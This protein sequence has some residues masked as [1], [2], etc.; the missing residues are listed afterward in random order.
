MS[1][2]PLPRGWHRRVAS[3]AIR[4]LLLAPFVLGLPPAEAQIVREASPRIYIGGEPVELDDRCVVNIGNRTAQVGADGDFAIPNVPFEAGVRSRVRAVCNRNGRLLYGSSRLLDLEDDRQPVHIF[5]D[6]Y[7]PLVRR[8]QLFPAGGD[9]TITDPEATL[10]IIALGEHPDGRQIFVSSPTAG[11]VWTS[12]D[13]TV[14]TVDVDGIVTPLR[15]GEVII[16][17]QI[18]G[19]SSSL[20]I[21]VD[22]PNDRDGDGL[23]DEYEVANGLDP[24]DPG[25]ALLDTDLDGLDNVQEFAAGT[26]PDL[27]DSDGDSLLDGDEVD[28]DLD[29]RR[30]DSDGDRLLDGEELRIGTDPNAADSDGDGIEDGAEVDFGLD[31]LSPDETTTVV[32]RAVTTEGAAVAGAVVLVDERFQ[33]ITN[34]AGAFEIPG[35][36]VEAPRIQVKAR[37]IERGAVLDGKIRVAPVPAGVTDVGELRL[38]AVRGAVGGTIV[39][40]RGAPVPGARVFVTVGDD[41]RAIN[42]NAAGQYLLQR[43]DEGPVTVVATDPTTGL[44]GRSV[45]ELIPDASVTVDVALTASGTIRGTVYGRGRAAVGEGIPVVLRGPV[46]LETTTDA[47]SRFQFDFIPLGVYT[48]EAFD[49]DGDR[50][51]TTAAINGTNQTVQAD[52]TFLGRGRVTGVVE[53]GGGALVAG[54]QVELVGDGPFGGRA[55]A[56][57]DAQGTF[58]IDDVFIGPF[59]ITAR[60]PL[61][62]LAATAS[63]QVRFEGDTARVTLTLR[64]AGNIV[65]TVLQSDE[66]TPLPG[67]RVTID[68]GGRQLEADAAGQVR[69]EGLP[70]GRYTVTAVDPETPDRGRI[71]VDLL[72]PDVDVRATVTLRGLGAVEVTVR[73]AGGAI[74]PNT[75]VTLTGRTPFPQTQVGVTDGDGIARFD[76]ILAGG[77]SLAAVEPLSGLT[78]AVDSNVLAD[79]V[80]PLELRLESAGV[81]TGTAVAA[82]G[83]T[84]VRGILMVLEPGG[85]RA[86]TDAA[87]R[88]RFDLVPVANGPFRIDAIDGTGTRR[89]RAE[90][91]ELR[92]HGEVLDRVIQLGGTGLV[93]GL[94]T[95]PEGVPVAGA[96]ITIDSAVDGAPRRF[97]TT[98]PAGVYLLDRIPEGRFTVSASL[99]AGR[100]AGQAAGEIQLDGEIIE[101]DVATARDV[102]PQPGGGGGGGAVPPSLQNPR[103]ARLFDANNLEHAIHQDGSIRNGTQSVF[104]GDGG[105]GSGGFLLEL[106]GEGDDFAPFVGRG[107]QLDLGGRQLSLPGDGPGGLEVTRRV[108]V[109]RD[110]YFVRYL[111]VLRNPTGAPITVDLRIRTHFGFTTEAR[112]G[113]TFTDPPQLVDSSSGDGFVLAGPELGPAADRWAVIDDTVDADPFVQRNAPAVAHVFDGAGGLR[114]ASGASFDLNGQAFARLESVWQA[115]TVPPGGRA[116]IMHFGVQQLDRFAALTAAERLAEAPPEAFEGIDALDLNG[117]LNFPRLAGAVD[118]LP[119]RDGAVSGVVFEGDGETTVPRARLVW[120]SGHPLFG[121]R[122][123]ITA[124]DDG[125]YAIAPRLGGNGNNIAIPRFDFELTAT[126]PNTGIR[127][128]ITPGVFPAEGDAAR[129]V[130]FGNAGLIGGVVRRADGNVVSTGQVF[131]RGGDFRADPR[132]DIAVDGRFAITGVPPGDYTVEARV[133]VADGSPLG[134]SARANLRAGET[135]DVAIV[136]DP[137]GGLVG[138]VR[139]GGGNPAIEVPVEVLGEGLERAGRSDTG[140]RYAFLDVPTGVVTARA[141]EPATGLWSERLVAVLDGEVAERDLDLVPLGTARVTVIDSDGA[142]AVDAPIHIRRAPLG[143]FFRAAGRTGP[144]GVL[145]LPIVPQ[146]DFT[147]RAFS[148]VNDEIA[149]EADGRIERHGQVVLV[150]LVVPVDQPPQVL[151]REPDTGDEALEGTVTQI[152]AEAIDDLGVRR[153]EFFADGIAIG[154]DTSPPYTADY[155]MPQGDGGA[156]TL[157]A[158]AVDGGQNRTIS[159]PVSLLRRDDDQI[160]TIRFLAPFE[161]AAFIEGTPVDIRLAAA[162]DVGVARVELFAGE[163]PIAVIEEPPFDAQFAA[164]LGLADA[165]PAPLVV[166]AAVTDRAGNRAEAELII[167]VVA[168]QPPTIEVIEAPDGPVVEG[169]AV[170]LTARATDDVGATVDLVID[171]RVAQTRPRAPYRFDLTAPPA[172]AEPTPV[173]LRARDARGQTAEAVVELEVIADTPPDVAIESPA[174]GARITEGSIVSVEASAVDEVGVAEV[175]FFAG[176]TLIATRQAPPYTAQTR[177]PGGAGGEAVTIRVEAVDT[178]GQTAAV[179]RDVIREDD[180]TPPTGAITSPPAGATLTVG[181]SDVML[182]FARDAGAAG[183]TALDLDEDG[184]ADTGVEAL[185]GIARRLVALFDPAVTRAGLLDYTDDATTWQALTDDFSAIDAALD[186]YLGRPAEGIP[187]HGAAIDE[188]LRR[189]AR[190]P[191][192]RAAAPVIFLFSAGGGAFPADAVARAVDAGAV[193]NPVALADDAALRQIADATGGAFTLVGEAVDL[194]GLTRVALFGADVLVVTAEAADDVAVHRLTLTVTGGPLDE[195]VVDE[196]APYNSI[197]SLP[198]LDGPVAVTLAG[199]VEDYGDNVTPLDPIPLT[200]RPADTAPVPIAVDPPVAAEGDAVR[201]TGRFFDPTRAGN[202]VRFGAVEGAATAATKTELIVQVPAGATAGITVEAGGRISAVLDFALDNDGDGLTDADEL[203]QG[204]DP[205]SADSDGD[206]LDDGDELAAGTAPGVADTDGDGLLDGFEVAAGFDP[207]AGDE[208]ADDPDGDGLDNLGEQAAG[209]DPGLIDSDGDGLGDGVEVIDVGSDPTRVDTDGGGISDGDEVRDDGTDPSAAGD[210][211]PRAAAPITLTDGGDFD[212]DVQGDGHIERGTDDAFDDAFDVFVDGARYP[213]LGLLTP[214]LGG[215]QLRLGPAALAGV[216][217]RRK[218][219]VPDDDRFARLLAIIDNPHPEPRAVRVRLAGNYGSDDET[220]VIG[221]AIADGIVDATDD[222]FATDDG[223]ALGGDPPVTLVFAGPGAALRPD[224]VQQVADTWRVEFPLVIPPGERRIVMHFAAQSATRAEALAQAARL[225]TLPEAALAGLTA[226]ERAAIVNF[227]ARP[228]ADGDGLA[229]DDE[230]AI[231]TRPDLPDTDGDGLLDGFEVDA[232]FDPLTAGEQGLDP[233]GDGLDNLGEQAAGTD[234]GAPDTDGDGLEDGDEVLDI[235][236]DP[237]SMDTD[238][239]GLGDGDEVLIHGSDPTALDSD[240]DGLD[241]GDE[242]LALGT[243]PADPDTDGDTM[244]DGYEFAEG[245]DP[246]DPADGAADPDADDLPNAGEFAAGSDPRV[247]DT[248]GDGLRDGEEVAIGT[249]PTVGDSD[250]GGRSDFDEVRADGTDPLD[251][252]DDLAFVDLPLTL[253]DGA[254]FEWDVQPTGAVAEG[255]QDAFDTAFR[256]DGDVFFAGPDQARIVGGRTL[257]AGPVELATLEGPVRITRHIFVPDDA[258]WIRYVDLFENPGG[259][260]LDLS[261]A[262]AGNLGSDEDTAVTA[263][264]SGDGVIGDGDDWWVTDDGPGGDPAVVVVASDADAALQPTSRLDDDIFEITWP[265]AIEAGGSAALVHFAAQRAVA[266]DGIPVAESLLRLQGAALAGLDPA[267]TA[268]V[269]NRVMV[270][271]SDGDDLRDDVEAALGTDP[272]DPDSDGDGLFDGFEAAAGFDPLGLDESGLDPDGDGLVNLGEQAAGTDPGVAD[273]DGD[274]LSD[275]AEVN[276]HGT[277]PLNPDTDGGGLSDGDEVAGG[278]DPLDGG[279]DQGGGG[280]CAFT[281]NVFAVAAPGGQ[282]A[283]STVGEATSG[284]SDLCFTGGA[285]QAV[286]VIDVEVA[287]EVSMVIIDGDFDTS[288]T[289]RTDCDDPGTELDCNDDFIDVLSGLELD[290]APGRYFLIIDGVDD[291]EE[292]EGTLEVGFTPL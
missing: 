171:G 36:V 147:V 30:A 175:R 101:V 220:T 258:G 231:G 178:A 272:A 127:S 265:L 223:A 170:R 60:D 232:G 225:A 179:T 124:R 67:A 257:I 280:L 183:Q 45:G 139:D 217:V 71:E 4:A 77:F 8:V 260:P 146:G 203:A 57:S 276:V 58:V 205:R 187:D 44:R 197:V 14:A 122:H 201:I 226:A 215:R 150:P 35:V 113:F 140:G 151:I 277:L 51:R 262:L 172:A 288:L 264:S 73:D 11:T 105:L 48:V 271:D 13:P 19:L 224:S 5:F 9:P 85:R 120:Q 213:E 26:A 66:E 21:R 163:D 228:D 211:L 50:G 92:D 55:S 20:R 54:A 199:A 39:G 10:P 278:T 287:S 1:P 84:P 269:V 119:A 12:S 112:G 249:D 103:V 253:V 284:L 22:I 273:T 111:E 110:G 149:V 2:S 138:A 221:S 81:I 279:D 24:D 109:P 126:H 255:T 130:R 64:S 153:V 202:T 135:L 154:S 165:Q 117:L 159:E 204:L 290:L 268:A 82:D 108:F 289:L 191:A 167:Q 236:S 29:P 240:G 106:R 166:T 181:P 161:G 275:G 134:G 102:I 222:W 129:D 17:A 246:N 194:A 244:P 242:V 74:S 132:A 208:G 169:S 180:D 176:G 137:V 107:G 174:P 43:F 46:T 3:H 87:G 80:L 75:R 88:F 33:A 86:F 65:A 156:V 142:P 90:G 63:G 189:L 218:I 207:I 281:D 267:L 168:D 241:D 162:D 78:G 152:V 123:G 209:S 206:G 177:L 118:P 15:R 23:P 239:D 49:A 157:T 214:Q 195:A 121:R 158:V 235:G 100:L 291:F 292:G 145:D 212:W 37:F 41:D 216:N 16:R 230:L 252:G 188:A 270:P 184:Q 283:F 173:T 89:G 160:P 243:D 250:G 133:P 274:G 40:P 95:D 251:G 164:P 247:F 97:T 125:T 27:P 261:V 182:A 192:R 62:G 254:G 237:R 196:A 144:G 286:A 263:D 229:D 79:E 59:D 32:G 193:V 248:D 72:D 148:P 155:V 285:G 7:Q 53:T 31:P 98:D 210:D 56:V 256:L 259:A 114:A 69:V 282:F 190:S 186:D 227:A 96:A 116:V 94:V 18:E 68:P 93:T 238:L 131:L 38:R 234:P 200:L 25:D 70:L 219:Y 28:R 141:Q 128:P 83:L 245:F 104:R 61:T 198:P 233:D 91:L 136:I 266:V 99:R 47:F 115:V 143:D 52:V 76:D 6:D 42:A 185:A 34:A